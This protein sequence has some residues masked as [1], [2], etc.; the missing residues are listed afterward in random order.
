MAKKYHDL[1]QTQFV[2]LLLEYFHEVPINH[3]ADQRFLQARHPL[4]AH[5]LKYFQNNRL[6]FSLHY[7]VQGAQY[8]IA[9]ST[10]EF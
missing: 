7:F 5:Y 4:Q 8:P 9:P 6:S 2:D 3:F 10:P 1:I